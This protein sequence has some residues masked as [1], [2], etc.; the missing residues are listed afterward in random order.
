MAISRLTPVRED[1][2]V[3]VL[4]ETPDRIHPRDLSNSLSYLYGEKRFK[5]SLQRNIYLIYI[6]YQAEE[7]GLISNSGQ[8]HDLKQRIQDFK[9]AQQKLKEASLY[10]M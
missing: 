10:R 4:T 3:K 9:L 8:G 7:H 1:S 2:N 5:I 6:Y